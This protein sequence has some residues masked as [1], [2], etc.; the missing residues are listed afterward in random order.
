MHLSVYSCIYQVVAKF[1]SNNNCLLTC[2]ARYL[3]TG[4]HVTPLTSPEWPFNT[5]TCSVS[6]TLCISHVSTWCQ[7]ELSHLSTQG[8]DRSGGKREIYFSTCSVSSTACSDQAMCQYGQGWWD[9]GHSSTQGPERAAGK[10]T[11]L[12]QYM[13]CVQHTMCMDQDHSKDHSVLQGRTR[14][15][16]LST[17]RWFFSVR[18]KTSVQKWLAKQLISLFKS[19]LC[20]AHTWSEIFYF[21]SC[22][23]LC[24]EQSPLPN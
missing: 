2:D 10:E 6:K 4:S 9:L 11:D 18:T 20:Q 14:P 22:C 12:F 13:F 17:W 7:R 16:H 1:S 24:L 5:A 15:G 19:Q 21:F 3:P 8:Q 23:T